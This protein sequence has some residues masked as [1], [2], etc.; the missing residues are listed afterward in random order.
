M[1]Q[2]SP[3]ISLEEVLDAGSL[4]SAGGAS[5]GYRLIKAGSAHGTLLALTAAF[6]AG[7]CVVGPAPR[8][9]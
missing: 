2:M 3:I 8:M 7:G 9:L 5:T 1:Q 4:G 6:G